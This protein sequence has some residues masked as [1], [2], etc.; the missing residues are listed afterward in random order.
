MIFLYFMLY[1]YILF[2][3]NA[4]KTKNLKK[5]LIKSVDF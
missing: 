4:K 3:K 2:E 5:K 1:N